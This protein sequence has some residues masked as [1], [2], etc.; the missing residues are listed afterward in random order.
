MQNKSITFFMLV[1]DKDCIFAKFGIR[2][3]KKIYDKLSDQQKKIFKLY[4]F[5]N[6]ISN[7]NK[8]KYLKSWGKIPYVTLLDNSEKIA[9]KSFYP[10][11]IIL[12]PEGI[13]RL[14]DGPNENYD[15]LW[16]T[17]LPK[18]E[19]DF[20]VTVD[21][22]F[23]ILDKSFYFH[24]LE[25]LENS[26]CLIASTCY[27]PTCQYFDTYSN[28]TINLHER[29]HTWFCIYR[30]E[31]FTYSKR[32]HFYYEEIDKKGEIQAYDS[33]AYFQ[34]ELR[35]I[36]G[37]KFVHLPPEYKSTFIHY[38]AGSKNK[39]LFDSNIYFYRIMTILLHI[40]LIRKPELLK[41]TVLTNKI[42]KKIASKLFRNRIASFSNERSSW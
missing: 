25:K 22:D 1:T 37:A 36:S 21:A 13:E 38:G 10:G 12:S 20:I 27:T 42:I 18:F 28:R 2:S 11:E 30:K 5:L 34:E 33:G 15:E 41:F 39:S 3:F 23:E 4:V 17:C 24:L 6:N 14:R 29:N 32:S 9:N 31:A 19:T 26:N 35:S 16:T 40:G 7:E 8:Q